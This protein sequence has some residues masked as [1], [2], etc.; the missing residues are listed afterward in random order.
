MKCLH[1]L[2]TVLEQFILVG[3]GDMVDVVVYR[4]VCVQI[5]LGLP[6]CILAWKFAPGCLGKPILMLVQHISFLSNQL[7]SHSVVFRLCVDVLAW[8]I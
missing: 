6:Q 3:Y 2:G 8:C 4:Q 7:K 5:L 1:G